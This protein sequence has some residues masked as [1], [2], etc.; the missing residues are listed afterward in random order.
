ME[1]II[2]SITI[3]TVLIFIISMV[4]MVFNTQNSVTDFP[5]IFKINTDTGIITFFG[6]DYLMDIS[7]LKSSKELAEYLWNLNRFIFPDL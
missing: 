4:I 5:E 2:S 7:F 6:E 3:L 1:K